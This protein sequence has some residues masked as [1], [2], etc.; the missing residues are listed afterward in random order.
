MSSF[1]ENT[2]SANRDA[3]SKLFV[4]T[5]IDDANAFEL[6]A[7]KALVRDN[8]VDGNGNT[9]SIPQL[10]FKGTTTDLSFDIKTNNIINHDIFSSQIHIVHSKYVNG[11]ATN[12]EIDASSG[13]IDLSKVEL[14]EKTAP[15]VAG[16]LVLNITSGP[17]DISLSNTTGETTTKKHAIKFTSTNANTKSFTK[18]L[19]TA[20]EQDTN[21]GGST[22]TLLK[23]KEDVS[24][25]TLLDVNPPGYTKTIADATSFFDVS[26]VRPD[27]TIT[28]SFTG[29]SRIYTNKSAA[30]AKPW[31]ISSGKYKIISQSEAGLEVTITGAPNDPGQISISDIS[32]NPVKNSTEYGDIVFANFLPS[33]TDPEGYN[34]QI[35]L[36]SIGSYAGS[37]NNRNGVA[38]FAFVGT[39]DICGNISYMN[40][41]RDYGTNRDASSN[42]APV[43][44]TLSHIVSITNSVVDLQFDGTN[45][46]SF[47]NG[48]SSGGQ[49]KVDISS[50]MDEF[51]TDISN[52]QIKLYK[53]TD[54]S[55]LAYLNLNDVSNVIT[56]TKVAYKGETQ[57][58]QGSETATRVS[59]NVLDVRDVKYTVVSRFPNP[60]S[61]LLNSVTVSGGNQSYAIAYKDVSSILFEDLSINVDLCSTTL[62]TLQNSSS[63]LTLIRLEDNN[64]FA[65]RTNKLFDLDN[66]DLSY[67]NPDV[68]IFVDGTNVDLSLGGVYNFDQV[69]MFI[70]PKTLTD[71]SG[72]VSAGVHNGFNPTSAMNDASGLSF[73]LNT[74]DNHVRTKVNNDS[75]FNDLVWDIIDKD[76]TSS[77]STIDVSFDVIPSYS[78]DVSAHEFQSKVQTQ[79]HIKWN[80]VNS[81]TNNIYLYPEDY[82]MTTLTDTSATT[83]ALTYASGNAKVKKYVRT[84]DVS[85]KDSFK[86]G[87]YDNLNIDLSGIEIVDTFF[88]YFYDDGTKAPEG[89]LRS[90]AGDIGSAS[91]VITF[92]EENRKLGLEHI[93]TMTVQLQGRNKDTNAYNTSETKVDL[94]MVYNQKTVINTFNG[95]NAPTFNIDMDLDPVNDLSLNSS[96]YQVILDFGEGNGI[97]NLTTKSGSLESVLTDI[98][99]GANTTTRN[100]L[101]SVF[102]ASGFAVDGNLS[103]VHTVHTVNDNT[104]FNTLQV[105]NGTDVLATFTS[106]KTLLANLVI[107]VANGPVFEVD[108]VTDTLSN[109]LSFNQYKYTDTS[110]VMID[111]GVRLDICENLVNFNNT[112]A[113]FDL[114]ED[115]MG[116]AHYNPTGA[117]DVS[118]LVGAANGGSLK[119]TDSLAQT[120]LAN[121]YRGIIEDQTIVIRR[122]TGTYI[123]DFSGNVTASQNLLATNELDIS[124]ANYGDLGF[125]LKSNISHIGM[126]VDSNGVKSSAT[127]EYPI[128]ITPAVYA[129]TGTSSVDASGI[130]TARSIVSTNVIDLSYDSQGNVAKVTDTNDDAYHIYDGSFNTGR[131]KT[132][133]STVLFDYF[134]QDVSANPRRDGIFVADRIATRLGQVGE[135]DRLVHNDDFYR[136]DQ[137]TGQKY[138]VFKT[139][140]LNNAVMSGTRKGANQYA[141]LEAGI[142]ASSIPFSIFLKQELGDGINIDHVFEIRAPK[143]QVD[144]RNAT[145]VTQ[146]PIVVSNNTSSQDIAISRT[147][148]DA[149]GNTIGAGYSGSNVSVK[150]DDISLNINVDVSKNYVDYL[151]NVDT[152]EYST[153]MAGKSNRVTASVDYSSSVN[154]ALLDETIVT[155]QSINSLTKSGNFYQLKLG[156]DVSGLFDTFHQDRYDVCGNLLKATQNIF[157]NLPSAYINPTAGDISYSFDMT[158]FNGVQTSLIGAEYDLSGSDPII[159]IR[160]YTSPIASPFENLGINANNVRAVRFRAETIQEAKIELQ[161]VTFGSTAYQFQD[162][163]N[164]TAS[165]LTDLEDIS[166]T[167]IDKVTISNE[168]IWDDYDTNRLEYV[169]VPLSFSGVGN[170]LEVTQTNDA[171]EVKTLIVSTPDI[172]RVTS[173]DGAPVF[174]L[175]A[176]G[177]IDTGAVQTARLIA[178]SSTLASSGTS[179]SSEFVNYN[180]LLK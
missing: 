62:A 156:Q 122:T 39:D 99:Y 120:V 50:T 112:D 98:S 101:Q 110:Y 174:R 117:E 29:G 56:G 40:A 171:K 127:T 58:A 140:D 42:G 71:L 109:D 21:N 48:I 77:G 97:W 103:T 82:A 10:G 49:F 155:D 138:N 20:S 130:I 27:G 111:N 151:Y 157:V 18:A 173:A 154:P 14:D 19:L 44:D 131:F 121:A 75:R 159:K 137:A 46:V 119:F 57:L 129:V 28:T 100:G 47:V 37:F 150:L 15:Y 52:G 11:S 65:T 87:G 83:V 36:S 149:D 1:L 134:Q 30:E 158:S 166:Y 164:A 144:Y 95:S 123:V 118:G 66:T 165:A 68:Q 72:F 108:R 33:G 61:S 179:P 163:L 172:T 7:L 148:V 79:I 177:R 78:G 167:T 16:K 4:S 143:V 22:T 104:G 152:K 114:L 88:E 160:K 53:T 26:L 126:N 24:N 141:E 34:F 145:G 17:D 86:F 142:S 168:T 12:Q 73:S 124:F 132:S 115:K 69:R 146:L 85:I 92:A 175:R 133:F 55:R 147:L 91:K 67:S 176:N 113:S 8:M 6:T 169:M 170:L 45:D 135:A 107:A 116:V 105:K 31:V 59:D 161:P 125:E 41:L 23:I 162:V 76:T 106:E 94:D 25:L 63:G 2:Q 64:V 81:T 180:V 3:T 35:D 136:V 80:D 84:R 60:G 32:G 5:S 96:Q 70:E 93:K 74:G 89:R 51:L 102:N 54:T 139:T 128:T 13:V 43:A 38:R 90:V 153:T 178:V 9:I